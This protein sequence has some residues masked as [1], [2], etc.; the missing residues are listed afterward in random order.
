MIGIIHKLYLKHAKKILLCLHAL[1][2][3]MTSK[4]KLLSA[5]K[6][7]EIRVSSSGCLLV[8]LVTLPARLATTA[9]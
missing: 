8:I 5:F 2:S 1:V 6:T 3:K 7:L 9:V 4:K